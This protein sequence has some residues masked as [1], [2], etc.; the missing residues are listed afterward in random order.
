MHESRVE[1]VYAGPTT[2]SATGR[3]LRSRLRIVSVLIVFALLLWLLRSPFVTPPTYAGLQAAAL[4]ILALLAAVLWSRVPLDDFRLRLIE[5]AV[6]GVTVARLIGVD[7][8]LLRDRLGAGQQMLALTELH[9]T[10]FAVSATIVLYGMLVPN[11]WYRAL[12]VALLLAA[13]PFVELWVLAERHGAELAALL[14]V[15][16]VE[17]VTN[18]VMTMVVSVLVAVAGATIIYSLHRE[19]ERAHEVGQYFLEDRI[20]SG[21]MGEIWR[22][23]HRFLA[24]PAAIKVIHPEK[25]DPLDPEAAALILHRFEQEAQATAML[26]SLHTVRIYDFGRTEQGD[27]Y[28]AMELLSGLDLDTL[29]NRFGPVTPGRLIHL[30][31]QACDSLGEAHGQGHIHRDVKPSNLFVCKFGRAYDVVKVLDFGLVTRA[32]SARERDLRLTAEAG[33][34]GTPAFMAPEQVLAESE[35]DERADIYALGCVAYWLLTGHTVFDIERPLAMAVAHVKAPPMPPSRRTELPVPADLER[36]VMRCLQKRAADRFPSAEALQDALAGCG[37]H[38]SWSQAHA[39]DWWRRHRP[40][41][42][43]LSPTEH[44]AG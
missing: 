12:A 20:A 28:Y 35:I 19:A 10:M 42:P 32:G 34:A 21:G 36:V 40:L 31:H 14:T 4:V 9:N 27:F 23:R 13:A 26:E 7:Y 33:L 41:E 11:T 43:A 38:G 17:L 44:A 18:L 1:L 22:A 29:V 2:V 24:R 25:I 5:A 16:D 8:L 37:D 6:F 30:L 3:L 15:G 39:R